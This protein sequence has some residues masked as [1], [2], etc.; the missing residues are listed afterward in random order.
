MF[1]ICI[2]KLALK[3][4]KKKRNDIV[5]NPTYDAKTK[6]IMCQNGL[7]TIC[8]SLVHDVSDMSK[9]MAEAI[10]WQTA[11][12]N[13]LILATLAPNEF[14]SH[15]MKPLTKPTWWYT[16]TAHLATSGMY[17]Q[18]DSNKLLDHIMFP[19]EKQMVLNTL[20]RGIMGQS[21]LNP[22]SR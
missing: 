19:T 10:Y 7:L 1:V 2:D 14:A 13:T 9:S 15:L 16:N 22:E 18:S 8:L 17:S 6:S 21:T 5:A 20:A 4:M 12:P 11:G 3:I